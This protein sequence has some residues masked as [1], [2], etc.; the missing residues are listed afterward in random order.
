MTCTRT[1]AFVFFLHSYVTNREVHHE[2][3]HFLMFIQRWT[4]IINSA[5]SNVYVE[6]C[7]MSNT[8]LVDTLYFVRLINHVDRCYNA[9]RHNKPAEKEPFTIFFL[10][11]FDNA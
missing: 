1:C 9:Y 5:E 3:L 10:P 4:Y 11:S 2:S 8:H 7:A 6:Q